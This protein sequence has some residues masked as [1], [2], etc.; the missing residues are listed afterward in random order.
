MKIGFLGLGK[1][2]LPCAL[3]ID[4]KGHDVM[5]YDI[6]P[7][8]LQKE[9]VAYKEE[10]PNGEPSIE[11]ILRKSKLRFAKTVR[12]L[13]EHA[14]IIF[15][16]I[17]TPHEERYE[18]STRL[19]AERRDFN[20]R[21]L[22]DGLRELSE[23]IAAVGQDRIVVIISTVLPGTMRKHIFPV[24]NDHVKICYN[25]FFIAMGTTMRDFLHPELVLLGVRDD[26]AA[27]RVEAFYKTVVEAPVYR[28]TIEN[29]EAIKVAYNTY[30]SMKIAFANTWMEICH[31]IPGTDVDALTGAL[32]LATTRIMS[33]KYLKGGMGD[34]GG[35]HPRDNIALSW[36]ARELDLSYDFFDSLMIA[37]ERQTEWLAELMESF[38]P[39]EG[40]RR[41]KIIL[42]KSFKP[43]TNIVVGSPA[44][45]LKNLL[46]ERGNDV[47]MY[48]PHVDVGMPVPRYPAG[49][50]L[51][52]TNHADFVRFEFPKG[53]VV[54]DPWR[55]L[56]EQPEG[57]QLVSVGRVPAG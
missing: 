41:L 33:P 13:V 8:V 12:D 29:A 22:T 48:D 54:I 38:D 30:I 56:P 15:V 6:N 47:E 25:P 24:L 49:V 3:A 27:Q 44:I 1:L 52:G 36:L 55:Y 23:Q 10:G 17:Q 46:Q 16:P 42:G 34:G 32:A 40:G 5:G 11:P 31:K 37:R 14:E 9:R 4:S 39:P 7:G 19:P 45:L 28:T 53:S 43:E 21:W 2:G 50:F 18:G 51:I 57:V 20:Y 35:C 26:D